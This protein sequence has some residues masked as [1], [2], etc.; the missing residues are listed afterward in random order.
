MP[1]VVVHIGVPELVGAWRCLKFPKTFCVAQ[2]L[3]TSPARLTRMNPLTKTTRIAASL[4]VLDAF[5]LNQGVVN[6][7]VVALC[8]ILVTMFVFLPRAFW[9]RRAD[10]RLYEQRLAKAGIYLL[11]AVAA[12]GCKVLQNRMADRRAI[13]IGSACL[14]FHAK[15]QHHSGRLDELVP[16]FLPSVPVAKYT[17]GGNNFFYF[18]PPEGREPILYYEAFSPSGRRF[19][20]METSKP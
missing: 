7:G 11:T 6:Q 1:V 16:D 3:L 20:H 15:Y 19:Y 13:K 18:S 9:A 17:L 8:L 5:I 10:R 14:A 4:F 2:S 12:F